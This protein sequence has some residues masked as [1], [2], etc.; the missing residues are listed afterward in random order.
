MSCSFCFIF[1]SMNC[2]IIMIY[3]S[4]TNAELVLLTVCP[5]YLVLLSGGG[6]MES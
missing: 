1:N 5:V 2:Y 4:R 6:S 3:A